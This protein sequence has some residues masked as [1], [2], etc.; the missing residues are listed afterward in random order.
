MTTETA[1]TKKGA[2][3]APAKEPSLTKSA[4]KKVS[5]KPAVA[6]PVELVEPKKVAK[7]VESEVPGANK[8]K[9]NSKAKV[10]RDSFSFPEH[11]YV[12]ISELKKT[13]LAA[14]IH[15]KKGEILRAGLLLLTQLNVTELKKIVEQVEKVQTGRPNLAK[16]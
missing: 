12:K 1:K 6:K 2:T 9:K 16:T 10:I 8:K 11:D 13:C 5:K 15:V 7:A 14:G 3:K 4:N